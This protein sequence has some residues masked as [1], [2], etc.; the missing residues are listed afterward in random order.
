MKL[1]KWSFDIK[2]P[3]SQQNFILYTDNPSLNYDI[4]V[5]VLVITKAK[6][7]KLKEEKEEKKG[8]EEEEEEDLSF[9]FNWQQWGV[10]SLTQ[11]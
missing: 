3:I 1:E 8:E 9:F 5:R 2:Q 10:G 4:D 7:L 6:S 11:R